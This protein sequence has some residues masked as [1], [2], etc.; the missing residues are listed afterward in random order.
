MAF[1]KNFRSLLGWLPIAACLTTSIPACS[2]GW[3]FRSGFHLPDSV[4]A[5]TLKYKT[6]NNLILLPVRIND[7]LRV[8]LILDTGTRNIV[9]FG[10]RFQK[11]FKFEPS[12]QV[13]FSGL[14]SGN[15]VFGKL[16]INN[17][18]SIQSVIGL[19]I[20]IVVVPNKNLF[21]LRP[22]PHEC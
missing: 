15:P 20:P 6:I 3:P 4:A 8:N 11:Y 2:T 7:T 5:L 13:Q 18:V 17:E 12:Q 1:F 14:G 9:L 22:R 10:K 21:P 16:S 19:D